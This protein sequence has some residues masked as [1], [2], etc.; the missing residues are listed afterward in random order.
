V[1]APDQGPPYMLAY[2]ARLKKHVVIATA[3]GNVVAERD[4]RAEAQAEHDRLT[5]CWLKT[6]PDCSG[7][8]PPEGVLQ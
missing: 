5:D 6:A 2:N 8:T 4:T 3:T 1:I 7:M